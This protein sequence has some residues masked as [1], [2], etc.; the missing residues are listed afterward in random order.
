MNILFLSLRCP[1]PPNR[2][3]RIRN[4]YFIKYLAES[5]RVTLISFIESDDEIRDAQ[6]LNRFCQRIEYVPFD[7]GEAFF[8]S[9]LGFFSAQPLQVH[10]WRSQRMQQ[11]IEQVLAEDQFD[12]IHAHLFRMGQYVSDQ[13]QIPKVLDLC[14]S[15]AL[16]LNRRSKLDRSFRLPLLK[17]E[18]YRVRRYEVEMVQSFDHGVV[19]AECDYDYLLEQNPDLQLTVIPVGVDPS[20]FSSVETSEVA[21]PP[22]Q[23]LLFTGT[24]NYFPNVDA[25]RYF[26]DRILP[27]IQRHLPS[28]H[29]SIVGTNPDESI[30]QLAGDRVTVTG[31]VPDTRPYFE[32]ATVFVSPMRSG[33]GLQVKHLE[34]MAMGVPIVTTM[35]G[36]SGMDA[37]AGEH[38][39][40]A[41]T[42]Q[43]FAEQII[44]LL[45]DDVR[46]EKIGL[47]GQALV[48]QKYDWRI[49]GQRLDDVYQRARDAR[50]I[51]PLLGTT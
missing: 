19:V 11:K 7:R 47:A 41:E 30:Q 15:L 9:A 26:H 46:R 5:H 17:L 16:N 43:V 1:F 50:L 27:I 33:S 42:P 2:G 6:P 12:L 21:A 29:L 51:Q 49:L 13:E 48:R 32:Q 23:H 4:Y 10:Y 14:D 40:V 44:G 22:N 20:Y 35:L 18:E 8:R 24:M 31:A 37:V 45:Q 34:A 36:A 28:V 25:V 38:L 3:D 39:L